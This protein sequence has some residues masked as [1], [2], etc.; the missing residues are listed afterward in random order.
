M[1]APGPSGPRWRKLNLRSAVGSPADGSSRLSSREA[2]RS[3]P[4]SAG[5]PSPGAPLPARLNPGPAPRALRVSPTLLQGCAAH[6]SR[7]PTASL[8]GVC[9]WHRASPQTPQRPVCERVEDSTLSPRVCL[10]QQ[11]TA[12]LPPLFRKPWR[13]TDQP[14]LR[15]HFGRLYA[16][17][18]VGG[19]FTS[20][21][22]VVWVKG[23]IQ[24]V[25]FLVK[26]VELFVKNGLRTPKGKR[27]SVQGALDCGGRG[28]SCGPFIQLSSLA[29]CW[30]V[31]FSG[32]D[33]G[34]GE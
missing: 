29:G 24:T 8:P 18:C 30:L 13:A 20:S 2:P 10:R 4:G 14:P 28:L 27:T 7:D 6:C 17:A 22:H 16:L 19:G 33:V 9:V 31:G 12:S 34:R 32:S 23:K 26:S 21:L 15:V 5:S 25:I 3:L 1:V 11:C